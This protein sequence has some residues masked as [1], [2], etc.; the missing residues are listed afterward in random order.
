MTRLYDNLFV[1]QNCLHANGD[2]RGR[3]PGKVRWER[4]GEPGPNAWFTDSNLREAETVTAECKVA[5]LIE[6][7]ELHPENY[8]YVEDYYHIFDYVVSHDQALV[9]KVQGVP[10]ISGG[11]RIGPEYWSPNYKKDR[12]LSIVAS[13]KR[14]M[15]GHRLR[16]RIIE[17]EYMDAYGPEYINIERKFNALAPYMFHVAIENCKSLWWLTEA[18]IDPLLT[19][20]VPIYWGC[21]D[22]SM[23]NEKGIIQV[24]DYAELRTAIARLTP[25]AYHERKE[26]ILENFEL[27]QQY[28]MTED[29]LYRKF[30]EIFDE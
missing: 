20:T 2:N 25:E 12:L 1:G 8:Q 23:F 7:R 16:H 10:Y 3:F 21:P 30:P 28:H 22:V 17:E 19:G 29:W 18:L 9:D 26:A 4:E 27:A 14:S 5:W 11:T 6:P 13:P 15:E 24:R